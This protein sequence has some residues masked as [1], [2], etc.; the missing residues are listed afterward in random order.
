MKKLLIVKLSILGFVLMVFASCTKNI[1]DLND[2]PKGPA[3]V[4]GESLVSQAQANLANYYTT[5]DV[6]TNI[7][8]LIMQFWAETTYPQESQY[9]LSERNIPRFWWQAMY[10]SI[11]KNL[12]TGKQLIA[13][14][15]VTPVPGAQEPSTRA[16]KVAITEICEVYTWAMLVNTFGNIPYTEALDFTK[17]TPKY[18]DQKTVFYALT[19]SL[20]AALAQLDASGESF[21]SADL[22]YG[23]DVSAWIKF[24]NTLKLRMGMQLADVDLAKAKTMVEAAAPGA[25]ASNDDNG[26]FH[27]ISNPPNTNPIWTNLVQSNRNDFVPTNTIVNQMNAGTDPRLS[28]YFTTG[29][30]GIYIGGVSGNGNTYA[31]FSH[32]SGATKVADFPTLLLDFAEVQFLKAEAV[33]RGFSVGSG[34]AESHYDSAVTASITYWGGS[35][36][37]A[38]TYLA[39]P[40]VSYT[41][42]T[43]QERI[44]VQQWIAYYLRG[45]DAWTS[46][47]RLGWP[48][49]V[50]PGSAITPTP[51]RFTY[52]DNE[53]TLNQANWTAASTAI[54]GDLVTTKLFWMK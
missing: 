12:E 35:A 37:D 4:P 36:G 40:G 30:G 11:L 17:A 51:V 2:N 14:E 20:D 41:T 10:T 26:L 48:K 18:D 47:R 54:G 19:D 27:F 22:L 45:F 43:W 53:Q 50:A 49:I 38:A 29:P 28:A 39:D 16:N 8:E 52:P 31:N 13:A 23:G 34:T 33:E 7:F 25:F 46:W 3:V 15:D 6:N 44:G 24:G 32:A 1:S 5:P 9:I 42:A 21:G